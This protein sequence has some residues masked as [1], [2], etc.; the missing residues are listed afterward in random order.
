MNYAGTLYEDPDAT[1][2]DLSEAV[3]KLEDVERTARRVLGGAHP[4]TA[5][6]Q[7]FLAKSRNVLAR[8]ITV[9][10]GDS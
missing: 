7:G 3:T 8:A 2:D 10:L 9:A 4:T 5:S 1:L 6:I